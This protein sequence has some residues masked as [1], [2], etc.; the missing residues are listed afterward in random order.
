MSS[1]QLNRHNSVNR[2]L[3]KGAADSFIFWPIPASD[4]IN[5]SLPSY[6]WSPPPPPRSPTTSTPVALETSQCHSRQPLPI[7][8]RHPSRWNNLPCLDNGKDVGLGERTPV[9]NLDA[10]THSSV[11]LLIFFT[12]L[13]PFCPSSIKWGRWSKE[14]LMSLIF[15]KLYYKFC[16]QPVHK[17]EYFVFFFFRG[18]SKKE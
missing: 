2:E 12:L 6:P 11:V 3:Q 9:F 10:S 8:Q 14:S 1:L 18:R 16:E 5:H 4:V 7:S 15:V 13:G 17:F